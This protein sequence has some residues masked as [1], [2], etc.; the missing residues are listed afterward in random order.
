V[1]DGLS[2]WIAIG[3]GWFKSKDGLLMNNVNFRPEQGSYFSWVF[4]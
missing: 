1:I 3:M 2:L 4:L